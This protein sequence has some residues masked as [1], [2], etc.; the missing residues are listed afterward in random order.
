MAEERLPAAVR[1]ILDTP[2]DTEVVAPDLDPIRLRAGGEVRDVEV[3]LNRVQDSTV[4]LAV[5]QASLRRTVAEA[6]V[7]LG[8]RNQALLSRQL[9]YITQLESD[10]A[11]PDRLEHLFRLDHLATRMRRNAESLLVLAGHAP[12]RTWSV[13]VAVADVVRGALGEVEGY[14]R[15]RLCHLD[16]SHVD[17]AAAADVSHVVAELVENAL[18]F[19]PPDVDVEVYGRRDDLSYVLTVVDSGIGMNADDLAGA[20]ALLASN[21]AFA[22]APSRFLGHFVVAQLAHRHDMT[23]A[24]TPSPSG[25]VTATVTL[26]GAMIGAVGVP[27]TAGPFEHGIASAPAHEGQVDDAP[28]AALPRRAAAPDPEPETLAPVADAAVDPPVQPVVQHEPALAAPP[29]EVHVEAPEPPAVADEPPAQPDEPVEAPRATEAPPSRA[30]IGLGTFAD[31]RATSPARPPTPAPAPAAEPVPARPAAFTPPA[32][33]TERLD[34]AALAELAQVVEAATPVPVP[35]P[36]SPPNPAISEDLLPNHLPRRGRRSNS[37]QAPWR[38]DRPTRVPDASPTTPAPSAVTPVPV[39]APDGR[40]APAPAPTG[41]P[42]AVRFGPTAHADAVARPDAAVAGTAT[43]DGDERFAFF[44]AFR[45]AAERA[46]EEA[47]IDNRRIG[48]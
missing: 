10:E 25:G 3:A 28:A 7:N 47:G 32:A 11:D 39:G 27:D 22:V 35:A 9:E 23:V 13:P 4:A 34:P 30:R 1:T 26:P 45:A 24:L 38:R 12:P 40:V 41:D 6:Y 20:N 18:T 16:D 5:Q 36:A 33:P 8:R 14:R 15:V 46:R 19:S 44:A 2:V 21:D 17:G 42:G 29:A 37:L 31:L 48:R 43:V